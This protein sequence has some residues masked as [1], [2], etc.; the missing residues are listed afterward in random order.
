MIIKN[1]FSNS[2]LW[3]WWL[4]T[5]KHIQVAHHNLSLI[6]YII[7][8]VSCC[9]YSKGGN[10]V[11]RNTLGDCVWVSQ[12]I[13][14]LTPRLFNIGHS[15]QEVFPPPKAQPLPILCYATIF[16]LHSPPPTTHMFTE[17]FKTLEKFHHYFG[18]TLSIIYQTSDNHK[19]M[20]NHLK[21]YR[22]SWGRLVDQILC[23]KEI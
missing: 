21:Y 10:L 19:H 3:E 2:L 20:I 4:P 9:L 8:K 7:S 18:D 14:Y 22:L 15:F 17:N 6:P 23:S 13:S 11:F 12:K 5:L 1:R 16:L